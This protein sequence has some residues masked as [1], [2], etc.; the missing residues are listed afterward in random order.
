[1][2]AESVDD[3]ADSVYVSPT[4]VPIVWIL[5]PETPLFA[6]TCSSPTKVPFVWIRNRTSPRF[7]IRRFRIRRLQ[8]RLPPE[9]YLAFE[10]ATTHHSRWPYG[11]RLYFD[12]NDETSDASED[13]D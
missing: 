9:T 13:V 11:P 1:M 7:Q 3:P 12:L 2:S 4:P 6:G 10:Y 8:I 5:P